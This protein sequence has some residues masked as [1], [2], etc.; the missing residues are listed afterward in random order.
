MKSNF[1][2]IDRG[3]RLF[4]A[5]LIIDLYLINVLSGILALILLILAALFIITGFI[6]FCPVYNFF[7]I[8]TKKKHL[9]T[10]K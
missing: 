4:L 9:S 2:Y 5:I 8:S 7:G 3:A 6:G 10:K 1:G